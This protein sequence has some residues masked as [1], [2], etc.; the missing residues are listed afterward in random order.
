M[1]QEA[2]TNSHF[3]LIVF[4]Y[5]ALID[6]SLPPLPD[7]PEAEQYYQLT[8]MALALEPVL[9]QPPL[10]STVQTLSL[11]AIYAW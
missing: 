1:D 11:M 6:I 5:G 2:H 10:V 7:N 9:D 4:A 3:F 8:C